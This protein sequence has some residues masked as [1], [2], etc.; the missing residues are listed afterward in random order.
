MICHYNEHDFD[1]T[2]P[3]L[4][5]TLVLIQNLHALSI[6]AAIGMPKLPLSKMVCGVCM[7]G[8]QHKTKRLPKENTRCATK[9]NQFIHSDIYGPFLYAFLANSKYFI[10]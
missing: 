3:K 7:A 9:P 1:V 2:K 8:K 5:P 4:I 6:R 10:T